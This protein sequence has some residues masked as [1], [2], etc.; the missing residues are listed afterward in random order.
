L[1]TATP[2]EAA[3]LRAAYEKA[4]HNWSDA[5]DRAL[6]PGD[7]AAEALVEQLQGAQQ[8]LV[9]ACQHLDNVAGTIGKITTSVE[10]ASKLVKFLM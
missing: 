8:D 7:A 2:E 5:V 3:A 9:Q 1:P 6:A 10:I 4:R